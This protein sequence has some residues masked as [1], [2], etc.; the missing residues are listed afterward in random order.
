MKKKITFHEELKQFKKYF[1]SDSSE[2]AKR[3]YLY[4]FFKKLNREKFKIES[5]AAGADV[6][7]EGQI[8]VESKTLYTKWKH[9][10]EV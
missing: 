1:F 7:I 3:P 4:P 5:D 9:V 8:I 6:Y 2:D 10:T